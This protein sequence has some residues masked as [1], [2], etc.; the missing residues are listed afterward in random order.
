VAARKAGK[1]RSARARGLRTLQHQTL[2]SKT[3]Y[4]IDTEVWFRGLIVEGQPPAQRDHRWSTKDQVHD[5]ALGWFLERHAER[6]FQD[7]PARRTSDEDLTFWVDSKLMERARHMA[8]RDGVKVARLIDAALS[9]Y[10]RQRLP[11][12][13]LRYRQR[14]QAEARRLY[15]ARSRRVLRAARKPRTAPGSRKPRN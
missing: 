3:R 2:P 8:E 7:Y 11:E 4:A 6:V 1:T 15:E 12:E 5:E 10:V 9:S 13:L 14:V